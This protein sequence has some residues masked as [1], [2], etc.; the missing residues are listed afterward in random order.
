MPPHIRDDIPQKLAQL[1]HEAIAR[2][3]AGGRV[4]ATAGGAVA[5]EGGKEGGCAARVGRAG[6]VVCLFGGGAAARGGGRADA[7]V[8]KAHV[9]VGEKRAGWAVV[10]CRSSVVLPSRLSPGVVLE[11]LRDTGIGRRCC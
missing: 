3:R 9:G 5:G 2:P 7:V 10:R 11:Q 1:G 6:G 8:P 4:V